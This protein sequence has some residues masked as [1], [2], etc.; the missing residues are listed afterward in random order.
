M[1]VDITV[2]FRDRLAFL[3]SH[4]FTGLRA[5]SRQQQDHK[6]PAAHPRHIKRAL[7]ALHSVGTYEAAW[8]EAA[9]IAGIMCDDVHLHR[10][11]LIFVL[12]SSFLIQVFFS[13][14]SCQGF[15]RR[16]ELPR[17]VLSRF[18]VVLVIWECSVAKSKPPLVTD[19]I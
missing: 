7:R 16:K 1:L 9:Q 12:S 14:L 13:L 10:S 18:R 4:C 6:L 8:P 5:S 2:L 15:P 19:C 11:S 17:L 3:V